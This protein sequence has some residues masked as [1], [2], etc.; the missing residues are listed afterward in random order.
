MQCIL[1]HRGY[2]VG[3]SGVDGQFGPDT[4]AAVKRFQT[5]Q[6]ISVDG[7]VGPETW[8]HLRAG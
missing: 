7:Q 6:R 8:S 4:A 3:S 2:S 5:D 1:V